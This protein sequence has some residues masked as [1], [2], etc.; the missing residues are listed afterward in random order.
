M[1]A[2]G[3]QTVVKIAQ[4]RSKVDPSSRL[5]RLLSPS[6]FSKVL[7]N[8]A[9]RQ[10]N[11]SP[12]AVDEKHG[13]SAIGRR[14]GHRLRAWHIFAAMQAGT[15]CLKEP[16]ALEMC[17]V[18]GASAGARQRLVASLIGSR[19]LRTAA[20]CSSSHAGGAADARPPP[21]K[22]RASWSPQCRSFGRRQPSGWP[23]Q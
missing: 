4:Q 13:P 23:S 3:P 14:G 5:E 1:V 11:T 15:A 6:V 2:C 12:G 17:R 7:T 20:L 16:G 9:A 22:G 8:G 18:V 19:P 21:T 10:W